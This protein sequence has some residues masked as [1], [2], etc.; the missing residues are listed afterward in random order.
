MDKLDQEMVVRDWMNKLG[1]RPIRAL[2]HEMVVA[3]TKRIEELEQRCVTLE[4]DRDELHE[5]I[6]HLQDEGRST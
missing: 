4:A 1:S 5:G 3:Y 2:V 6:I